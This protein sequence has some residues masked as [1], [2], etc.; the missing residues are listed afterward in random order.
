M[1]DGEQL[2]IRLSKAV[3]T[4]SLSIGLMTASRELRQ[5]VDNCMA[6]GVR[7]IVADRRTSMTCES[8][9]GA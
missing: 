8:S 1:A 3:N 9:A 2:K 6:R 4:A 5:T 7:M